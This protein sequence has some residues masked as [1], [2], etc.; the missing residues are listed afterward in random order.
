[1]KRKSHPAM[2]LAMLL[3][4]CAAKT[5]NLTTNSG[6]ISASKSGATG[7]GGASGGTSGVG[8]GS[9]L[10]GQSATGG[11]ATVSGG[12]PDSAGGSGGTV[13]AGGGI[14]S[15]GTVG[16]GGD[17]S[18]GGTSG[19]GGAA[20]GGAASGDAA[21]GGAASGGKSTTSGSGGTLGSGGTT[22]SGGTTTVAGS[23]PVGVFSGSLATG[24]SFTDTDGKPV[25]A[26]GGGIVKD[27]DTYYLHGLYFPPGPTPNDFNGVA[28]YSSKDLATWKNE[29]IVLPQQPS[30]QLGPNRNCD[31]PHIIQC[32]GT[33]EFVLT[34]RASDDVTFE[35]D[36]EVVYATSPTV[37]AVYTFKG[38]LLNASGQTASHS[39]MSAYADETGAYFITESGW[40]YT[41]A[42]DCHSWVS[43]KQYSAV[44]GPSGGGEAPTVFKVGSTYYWIMSYKTGWRCNNNFYSTAPAM[45]GPWTYQ[46]YI[47]PVTD[48]SNDISDQRT[49]LS[50]TTWVQPVV[51]SKGTV[52]VYWGDHWNNCG[53]TG[54]AGSQNYLATYVF[55]PMILGTAKTLLPTYLTTWSLDVGAGTWSQ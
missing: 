32:P 19:F 46:G 41:L 34:A 43:G 10:G 31:R 13:S 37:N 6:G 17:R 14:G 29:G 55:Q 18:A 5:A 2:L 12:T 8:R 39:D 27:G 30:G 7:S 25:N 38:S 50:Q 52:Y 21:S 48:P 42:A 40:V 36:R 23:G 9:S 53:A 20:L 28:M 49:W 4:G 26:H 44:N 33:G 47:A 16:A 3:I 24:I 54:G 15:G 22:A 11:S 1:M 35:Q 45:S 51:G